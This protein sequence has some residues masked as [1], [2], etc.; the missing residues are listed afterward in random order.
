M[1]ESLLFNLGIIVAMT[2]CV[3]VTGLLVVV[4]YTVLD[5]LI[6]KLMGF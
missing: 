5:K 3:A 1:M 4:L 6:T 2:V